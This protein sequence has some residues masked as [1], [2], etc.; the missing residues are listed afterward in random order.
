MVI[1]TKR[2]SFTY[3]VFNVVGSS[4]KTYHQGTQDILCDYSEVWRLAPRREL[5][6]NQNPVDIRVGQLIRF[7]DCVRDS[8]VTALVS[9]RTSSTL[10]CIIE[11]GKDKGE[12]RSYDIFDISDC[13]E[14]F[15]SSI[16]K[17]LL[18]KVKS[19]TW[20]NGDKSKSRKLPVAKSELH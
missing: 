19:A 15:G 20:T 5:V 12:E 2:S 13:M 11:C 10:K 14:L 9:H 8:Y 1:E 16:L 3:R 7:S 18:T 4:K 17:K 6:R